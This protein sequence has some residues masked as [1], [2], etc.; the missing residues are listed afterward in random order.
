MANKHCSLKIRGGRDRWS[1][2]S[3]CMQPEKLKGFNTL[4][5]GI[6]MLP[7]MFGNRYFYIKNT[8]LI[9]NWVVII[10]AMCRPLAHKCD[11]SG[12]NHLTIVPLS[13][14]PLHPGCH[15]ISCDHYTQIQLPGTGARILQLDILPQ[16]TFSIISNN[17]R[18]TGRCGP[19]EVPRGVGGKVGGRL[20]Y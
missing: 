6:L 19:G 15:Q 11:H 1:F 9:R 12:S 14:V 17:W 10:L 16:C 18:Q 4:C 20:N 13:N 8:L 5:G 3:T 7:G 2:E